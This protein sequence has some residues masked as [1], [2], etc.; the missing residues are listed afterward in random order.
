M[1]QIEADHDAQT[2]VN[3]VRLSESCKQLVIDTCVLC[4]GTHR[5]G[6]YDR[7]VARGERSHRAEHCDGDHTGGYY[8]E[9]AAD[10]D[11]PAYWYEWLGVER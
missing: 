8:L 3:T 5:H 9:L 11:P 7:A 6:A 10:A 4:G 2:P 1:K